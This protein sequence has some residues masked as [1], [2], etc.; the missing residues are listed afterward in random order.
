MSDIVYLY[1]ALTVALIGLFA[2]LAYLQRRMSKIRSE[3]MRLQK[4]VTHDKR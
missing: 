2:Y 3:V 4:L 1:A